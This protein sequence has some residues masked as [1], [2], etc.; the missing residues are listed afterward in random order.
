MKNLN[1]YTIVGKRWFE[2]TYGNTYHSV[3]IYKGKEL[4]AEKLFT[5]GYEEHYMQTAAELMVKAGLIPAFEHENY[6][7]VRNELNA[8]CL[9]LIDDVSRKKDL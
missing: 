3:R 6:F 9:I 2:R 1:S 7:Q 8:N 5:Y 4:I